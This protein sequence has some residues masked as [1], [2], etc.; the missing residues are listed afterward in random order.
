V[1]VL[2]RVKGW[3]NTGS[4]SGGN[5]DSELVSL[6][7]GLSSASGVTVSPLSALGVTTVYACVNR[8]SGTVASV[9]LKLYRRLPGGGKEPAQDDPRY[10]LVHDSPNPEMTSV[11][12]RRTVQGHLSLRNNA[13]ALIVRNGLKNIAELRPI[14]PADMQ[15]RRDG[16]GGSLA[17]YLAGEYKRPED[18]IHLRNL[19]SNGVIGLDAIG[20]ARESIG[21]AIALHDNAARFFGNGCRPGG[22][23]ESEAPLNEEQQSR[24][25]EQW[26]RLFSGKGQHKL[27]ILD[28]RMKYI[29]QRVDNDS[30]Q[31]NES[32]KQQAIEI[33]QFYGTPPHKV[34]ILDKAT[35]SNIEEQNIEYV[36][37]TILP[38]LRVWEQTLN[39]RLLTERERGNLFFEFNVE[40]LLRGD[41]SKRYA[42]YAIGRQW[43]W[44][45]VNEIREKENMNPLDDGKG[46]VYL[47]PMNMRPAGTAENESIKEE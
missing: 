2:S 16:P 29:A 44:L 26:E 45:N 21:L 47:E 31:F 15:V 17:Y 20:L 34:G 10:H 27:A 40:G 35:F 32:R 37:D 46:D 18:I 14:E 25:R 43:G 23:I 36:V 38:Q 6:I 8:I 4:S 3:F 19:S 11:D 7:R 30:A 9:P 24:L 12:F 42:A 39:M 5:W 33:C 1:G 13:Y 22:I 28:K 41:I